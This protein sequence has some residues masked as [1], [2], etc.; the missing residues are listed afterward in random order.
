MSR[1]ISQARRAAFLTALA[2]TGNQTLA[3]ERTR[4]SRSWVT[5]HRST[6]PGFD[7]AVR[8]A[9]AG[10]RDALIGRSRSS[11][12]ES[13]RKPPRGWGFLD[14]EELV[15]RGTG[16]DDLGDDGTGAPVRR[17]VQV[18]RARL[19][20]WTARSE[21][22][23]LAVLAAIGNVR[24]ACAEAGLTPASAYAHR[25]RWPGFAAR[26]DEAVGAGSAAL[27][28]A[29]LDGGANLFSHAASGPSAA[30]D[31]PLPA[32]TGM[33]AHQALHLLYMHRHY[34][35]RPGRMPGRPPTT[36]T[37]E[38]LAAR[39]EDLLGR[40]DR[41]KARRAARATARREDGRGESTRR[42]ARE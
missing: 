17:R 9:V 19:Q 23:F 30:G 8:A 38:R 34:A 29:L 24:A 15:V 11:P 26:W 36:V 33:D 32:I 10:A 4:V 25:K 7:A 1:K 20:Q 13:G 27:D 6:D 3:A 37:P 40:L 16:G 41:R 39:I 18:A 35:P 12:E 28:A 5:L 42:P 14:G 22:R 2:E 31:A 21:E